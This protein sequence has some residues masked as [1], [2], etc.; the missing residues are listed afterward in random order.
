[1]YVVIMQMDELDAPA[2]LDQIEDALKALG[3][4]VTPVGSRVTCNPPPTDTDADYLVEIPAGEEAK[5]AV[6]ATLLGFA[7]EWEAGESGQYE[8]LVNTDFASWRAGHLNFIVTNNPDFAAKFRQ[9]SNL[10]KRL[11]LLQKEDR[12]AVFQAVLYGRGGKLA[13]VVQRLAAEPQP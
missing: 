11:N 5:Q 9:A 4:T 7:I 2:T 1:M 10:A 12:I 3:C 6:S 13:A 8:Q